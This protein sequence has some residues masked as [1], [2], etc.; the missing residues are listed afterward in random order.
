MKTRIVNKIFLA[1]II[2]IIVWLLVTAIKNETHTNYKDHYNKASMFSTSVDTDIDTK[3]SF[4]DFTKE[5]Y[6]DELG[7]TWILVKG[8]SEASGIAISHHPMC[9]NMRKDHSR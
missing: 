6:K 7:C 3:S 5:I 2:I 4:E 9:R 1:N 8:I